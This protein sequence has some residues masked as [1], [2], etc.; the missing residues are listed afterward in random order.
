M[1]LFIWKIYFSSIPIGKKLPFSIYMSQ[2]PHLVPKNFCIFI[3]HFVIFLCD[4]PNCLVSENRD[5]ANY[6]RHILCRQIVIWQIAL[7]QF[8]VPQSSQQKNVKLMKS[9]SNLISQTLVVSK[10]II[11]LFYVLSIMMFK[12]TLMKEQ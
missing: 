12:C 8:T 10:I 4:L 7:R 5:S 3:C 1:Q 6:R 9:V 11:V 2:V